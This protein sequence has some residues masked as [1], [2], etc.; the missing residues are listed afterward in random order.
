MLTDNQI[1]TL[2]D[3]GQ[4]IAFSPT[5]QDELD[6]LIRE[7]YVAKDGD[8]YELTAKGQKVLT[9]RGAGLNEA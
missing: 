3:I 7:G 5:R 1:A 2:S 9:D 4:A 6:D 8:I